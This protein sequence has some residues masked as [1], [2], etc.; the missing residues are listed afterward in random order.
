MPV[1]GW[2]WLMVAVLLG[3]CGSPTA[4]LRGSGV[5]DAYA[6]TVDHRPL[7]TMTT[8]KRIKLS[9]QSRLAQMDASDLYYIG[10]ESFY[11]TVY[12][13]GEYEDLAHKERIVDVAR[14]TSGVREV[15]EYFHPK[16]AQEECTL[17]RNL[18][19]LADVKSRLFQDKHIYGSNIHVH[20][21]QCHI[22]L[23]GVVE[24]AWEQ[25]RAEW[26]AHHTPGVRSAVSYLRAF[27]QDR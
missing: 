22:V 17:Y 6:I 3:G 23:A 14:T 15:V 16:S 5:Y 26:I 8:D 1:R 24:S 18:A 12:L 25:E 11:G 13:I 4:L 20:A 9:I 7:W 19:L 27:V 10:V 2:W 21:V